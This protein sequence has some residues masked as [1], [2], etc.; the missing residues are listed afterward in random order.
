MNGA[1]DDLG[2]LALRMVPA[3]AEVRPHAAERRVWAVECGFDLL[4][5]E[6]PAPEQ[7]SPV[8]SGRK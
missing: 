1:P 8:R 4:Y 7:I 5:V 6:T 2:G 3:L